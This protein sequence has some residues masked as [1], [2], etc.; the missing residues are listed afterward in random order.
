ML[1]K[2]KLKKGERKIKKK[3][4]VVSEIDGICQIKKIRRTTVFKSTTGGEGG[5]TT[6]WDGTLV[7]AKPIV[8][9]VGEGRERRLVLGAPGYVYN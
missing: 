1:N 4:K 9:A 6:G 2:F 5:G 3:E 8:S 7:L